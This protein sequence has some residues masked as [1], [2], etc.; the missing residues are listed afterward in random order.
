M[1]EGR[2]SPA[3]TLHRC[4]SAQAGTLATA[5]PGSTN[6]TSTSG[7]AGRTGAGSPGPRLR[8]TTTTSEPCSARL[9]AQRRHTPAG[10]AVV[11]AEAVDGVH[12]PHAM[13]SVYDD[14]GT[15]RGTV[16]LTPRRGERLSRDALPGERAARRLGH[17]PTFGR[18]E[19]EDALDPLAQRLLRLCLA[20]PPVYAML[21][22]LGEAPVGEHHTRHTR[23]LRF[24]EHVAQRLL[25]HRRRHVD[26]GPGQHARHVLDVA[27]EPDAV[28]EPAACT[29][30]K[31]A[32]AK[33]FRCVTA[34]A[35]TNRT[36][37]RA[38]QRASAASMRSPTPL[39]GRICPM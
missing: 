11:G 18:S 27:E 20:D 31:S 25:A 4:R 22:E 30:A 36:S 3:P 38:R 8:V 21:D 16:D 35:R 2:P 7:C 5:A 19:V 13:S 32:S 10:S 12:D 23:R 37:S 26:V 1:D 28:G 33:G 24:E 15:R 9:L 29:F 34:P 17:D 6:R 14:G 39:C